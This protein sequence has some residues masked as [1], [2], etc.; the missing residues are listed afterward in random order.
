MGQ[1]GHKKQNLVIF[2]PRGGVIGSTADCDSASSD[3][4]SG[5][6][7]YDTDSNNILY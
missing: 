4:S 7:I 1:R 2:H 3:S 6:G 5:H